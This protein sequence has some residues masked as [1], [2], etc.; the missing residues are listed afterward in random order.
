MARVS[1]DFVGGACLDKSQDYECFHRL[2]KDKGH[3]GC[4]PPDNHRAEYSRCAHLKKNSCERNQ[5]TE[6]TW[7]HFAYPDNTCPVDAYTKVQQL[8]DWLPDGDV[9]TRLQMAQAYAH[10][11]LETDTSIS[12][13]QITVTRADPSEQRKRVMACFHMSLTFR[14]YCATEPASINEEQP[15]GCDGARY[16][17]GVFT[18]DYCNNTDADNEDGW[19]WWETCCAWNDDAKS[20]GTRPTATNNT[21]NG[22]YDRWVAV[23]RHYHWSL[24]MSNYA[25]MEQLKN[26]IETSLPGRLES[27]NTGKQ[28]VTL[29]ISNERDA[30]SSN[31]T[32]VFTHLDAFTIT[33]AKASENEQTAAGRLADWNNTQAQADDAHKEAK[34]NFTDLNTA[35]ERPGFDELAKAEADMEEARL[36][37]AYAQGGVAEATRQHTLANNVHLAIN[38]MTNFRIKTEN[39][40][41]SAKFTAEEALIAITDTEIPAL[42]A[43]YDNVVN[44][45]TALLNIPLRQPSANKNE[46]DMVELVQLSGDSVNSMAAGTDLYNAIWDEVA[47]LDV[48]PTVN[49]S[50]SAALNELA[51]KAKAMSGQASAHLSSLDLNDQ[52]ITQAAVQARAAAQKQEG[53]GGGGGGGGMSTGVIVGIVIGVLLLLMGIGLGWYYTRK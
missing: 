13:D 32:D 12:A 30:I 44:Q 25:G 47:K 5:N 50:G 6:C 16:Q 10:E 22:L 27:F 53:G 17:S 2:D 52:A 45:R 15:P 23:A 11:N 8:V 3:A 41:N 33:R 19:L 18:Q 34:Q 21:F 4:R 24:A 36:K 28:V 35:E 40:A 20:C 38:A 46:Y 51:N 31:H 39:T 26:E 37:L 14:D 42:N 49:T 48:L 43:V 7:W 29:A 1:R 9:K